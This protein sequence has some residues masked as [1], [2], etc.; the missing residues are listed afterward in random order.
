[1]AN[2]IV[3]MKTG[4]AKSRA[5]FIA[6]VSRVIGSGTLDFSHD[7]EIASGGH[8]I[9]DKQPIASGRPRRAMP[10]EMP[11]RAIP[12]MV[13]LVFCSWMYTARID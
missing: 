12:S 5:D 8:A 3:Q 9:L 10:E 4:G 1:M 6:N 13:L 7:G 11:D 2:Y